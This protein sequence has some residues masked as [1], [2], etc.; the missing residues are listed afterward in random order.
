MS[1]SWAFFEELTE[2]LSEDCFIARKTETTMS[3]LSWSRLSWLLAYPGQ[4]RNPWVEISA[5]R[6]PR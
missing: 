3:R 6:L 1:S 2:P 5:D 4:T